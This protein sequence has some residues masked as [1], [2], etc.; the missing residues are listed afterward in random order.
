[1]KKIVF[2]M[3]I[4]VSGITF[5]QVKQEGNSEK[6][7]TSQRK[8]KGDFFKEKMSK[9]L[10]LSADQQAKIE[11]INKKYED[12]LKQNRETVKKN[13][14]ALKSVQQQKKAEIEKVLTPD[15]LAKL[16]EMKSEMKDKRQNRM[17][18]FK[19]KDQQ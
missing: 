6:T 14:S 10:N 18:N 7:S 19:E 13:Y 8:N 5:A 11:Q 9:E 12:Q 2:M 15:Q 17:K 16:K 4:L 1:M 3:L